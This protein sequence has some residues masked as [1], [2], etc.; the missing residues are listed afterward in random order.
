MVTTIAKIDTTALGV[1]NP[2]IPKP[3]GNAYKYDQLNRIKKS[4]SYS[5]IDMPGNLWQ[6]SGQT[7]ANMYAN[8]FTYDANGNILTQNRSDE[9]GQEFEALNYKYRTLAGNLKQN[10]LYHVN[11]N[12]SYT[13]LKTDDIDD[14]GHFANGASSSSLVDS[15]GQYNNYSYDNIGNLN[16]DKSEQ[17]ASIEWTVYGK[18]KKITRVSGSTRDN[19]IFDYDPMGNRIA[20]HVYDN[21]NNWRYSIYYIRDAQGNIMSTYENKNIPPPSGIGT[22][23][24]SYVL[25]EQHIYGSSRIGMNTPEKQLI[26]S[27]IIS[28]VTHNHF[29]G[30]KQFELGNHLGNILSVISNKKIPLDNNGDS[31]I[32]EYQTDLLSSNDY[33]PFGVKLYSRGS[34]FEIYRWGY[35]G[36]EKIDEVSGSGNTIDMG[37]R[38]LDVR[39]GRTPKPDAK[40]FLYPSVSPYAYALNNPIIYIDPDG[41]VVVFAN[42]K[43]EKLFNRIYNSASAETKA[44]L[45]VLKSSDVVY[46]INSQASLQGRQGSTEYNFNTNQVDIKIQKSGNNPVGSLGDELETASQFENGN[47]GFIQKNDGST[48]TLGYDMKDEAATKR[49]EI[50][51]TE[52]VSKAE[53]ITIPLDKTTEAFKKADTD[54]VPDG[55]T[56][57]GMIENYFNTDPSAK[58]YLNILDPRGK[59][60]SVDIP[61]SGGYS[62]EQLQGAKNAGQFKGFIY[63]EK[64]DGKNTTVKSQ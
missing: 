38:W 31:V 28:N 44:K 27:N 30:Q 13:S 26:S 64:V 19:I 14:Q 55:Q 20:K 57:E 50:N 11:D 48:G 2:Q 39:L 54:P 61:G 5:N 4:V 21:G 40:G 33:S 7:I 15:V 45:D 22:P 59:N 10:R 29:L 23:A 41:R 43:S 24:M 58:Q 63:R 37:D 3:L 52:A 36:H 35:G 47:L 62:K 49:A 9:N 12:T 6:S 17:I 16:K 46:N 18:V 60:M 1:A 42:K 34:F 32:D 25:Q 8:T 56:R 51:A 53:N